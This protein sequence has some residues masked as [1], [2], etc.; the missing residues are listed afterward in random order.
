MSIALA[1]RYGLGAAPDATLAEALALH[2]GSVPA[3]AAA[4]RAAASRAARVLY[5]GPLFDAYLHYNVEATEPHPV[6]DVLGRMQRSGVRAVIANS[7]P[8]D[9]TKALAAAREPARCRS[10]HRRD[11]VLRELAAGTEAGPY[12]GLGELHLYDSTNTDGATADAAGRAARPGRARP[13]AARSRPPHRLGQRRHAVRPR[14]AVTDLA[15][16]RSRC[17]DGVTRATVR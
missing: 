1:S 16:L 3:Q 2:A 17:R 13:P 14:R 10:G 11:G 9:G 8:N 4:S 6:G 7:R 5:I 12:R 15:Q